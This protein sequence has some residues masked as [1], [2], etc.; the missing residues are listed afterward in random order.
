MWE[1]PADSELEL[2]ESVSQ[3]DR[4]NKQALFT[5]TADRASTPHKWITTT[6]KWSRERSQDACPTTRRKEK[7][8]NE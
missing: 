6:P 7:L 2:V 8:N 1:V 3:S 4:V 5:V